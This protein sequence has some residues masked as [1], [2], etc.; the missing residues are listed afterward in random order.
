MTTKATAAQSPECRSDD[1]T[2][3]A[4]VS[5]WLTA[6]LAAVVENRISSASS[7]VDA[8]ITAPRRRVPRASARPAAK[9]AGSHATAI[10]SSGCEL[11]CASSSSGSAPETD[12]PWASR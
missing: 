10:R 7:P 1:R 11:R 6:S 8:A 2:C 12:G 5:L 9:P 4:N 3:S